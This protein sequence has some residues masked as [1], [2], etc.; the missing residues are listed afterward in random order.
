MDESATR[1]LLALGLLLLAGLGI[2]ALGKR[3]ALPRATLL[4]LFG[5]LAGPALLD[6]IPPVLTGS[7]DLVAGL[8]LV[9]IGFL[10]G[11]RL[12]LESLRG[13][14]RLVVIV[15]L[16]GALVTALVVAPA[17]WLAGLPPALALLLGCIAAATDP[18]ATLDVV[19][20]REERTAL[21]RA[22]V[23]IVALDDSWGL[24]IFSLG[25]SL[26]GLFEDHAGGDALLQL[27]RGVGGGVGLGLAL[28]YPAA[29]LTGRIRPGRPML[30][31]ATGLMFLCGGLAMHL[32]VSFLLAAIVMGATIANLAE[33]HDYPFHEIEG[34]EGAFMAIFFIL[35]GASLQPEALRQ[36]GLAGIVYLMA[37][38]VGKAAGGWSGAGLAGRGQRRQVPCIHGVGLAML[39]QAGAAI[40]M[41]LI[42]AERFEAHGHTVLA[43]VIGS[44]VVFELF[45]PMATSTLLQRGERGR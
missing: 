28:G 43:I 10:I 32:D 2:D 3:T 13:T 22:L 44:T 36:A 40:G 15:S 24:M 35:A 34:I 20:E 42:V 37:R 17:M 12:R 38:S 4:V 1:I 18:A 45:G 25:L 33:H 26:V 8:A 5:L 14:G 21:S 31:E 29:R 19:A 41:A 30:M 23:G 7:F 39:P 27:A 16:A 11:G 9:M 6:L